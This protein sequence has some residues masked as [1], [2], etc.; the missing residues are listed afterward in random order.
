MIIASV[1][2]VAGTR[3][4]VITKPKKGSSTLFFKV[5]FS[6][7]VSYVANND[8]NRS[9]LSPSLSLSL[10]LT[11]L[12]SI[13]VLNWVKS[14]E[15]ETYFNMLIQDTALVKSLW[16]YV[17]AIIS[18]TLQEEFM[19]E[20]RLLLHV[21]VMFLP[22]PVFFALF[23]QQVATYKLNLSYHWWELHTHTHAYHL[24]TYL[25]TVS[26]YRAQNGHYKP[27]RWTASWEGSPFN[28]TRCK[29]SIQS[30]C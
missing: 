18:Y 11:R 8:P 20:V 24:F 2:F 19:E 17:V 12:P 27:V 13:I 3:F 21:C 4:Y 28:Q 1:L 16:L 7:A 23:N 14:R 15:R 6:V 25:F 10:F 5:P 9:T 30:W 22:I 26:F 29:L